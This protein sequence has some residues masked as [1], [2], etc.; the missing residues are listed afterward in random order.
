MLAVLESATED[1]KKML[2]HGIARESC[3][4]AKQKNGFSKRILIHSFPSSIS[5]RFYDFNPIMFVRDCSGG[6]RLILGPAT[7]E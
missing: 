7:R 3:F 6:K 2:M 4:S 1:F 5:V